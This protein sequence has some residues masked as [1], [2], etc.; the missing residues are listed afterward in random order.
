[1]RIVQLSV[2]S[3]GLPKRTVAGA[4]CGRL[5]LNGDA[6]AH[7]N[8]HGGARKAI[9]VIA[10]EVIE[11][12]VKLGYPV[13]PGALGENITTSGLDISTLRLGDRLRAG[14]ALL[15]ITQPRGPCSALDVYGP[16]IKTEIYEE[17][18]TRGDPSSP[19][20]GMSGLY[21]AVVE[22]GEIH[23][24]DPIEIL[25]RGSVIYYSQSSL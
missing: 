11:R 15:E 2:S 16:A 1:M 20:W 24:G 14:A 17:R 19:L 13:F 7:P 5:G 12:L 8:I 4:F 6:H 18:V 23:S 22:E 3:G 10:A 9:L 21:A 25:R